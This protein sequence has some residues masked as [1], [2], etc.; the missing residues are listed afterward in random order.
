MADDSL[1]VALRVAEAVQRLKGIFIEIPGTSLSSKDA[2]RLSGLEAG[3]C[4]EV[5]KALEDVCFLKCGVDG[6][7]RRA[8]DGVVPQKNGG[9]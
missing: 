4:H 8:S 7:F 3:L 9:R 1:G 5:L 2:A 6:R